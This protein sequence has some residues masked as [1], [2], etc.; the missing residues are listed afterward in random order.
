MRERVLE[1]MKNKPEW[2]KIRPIYGET[3]QEVKRLIKESNLHT[4]CEE[5][6]CPNISE[7]FSARTATFM[8]L[9][10]TCTRTCKFCN[11]N[12]GKPKWY[13]VGEPIRVGSACAKLDLRFAVITSVARDDLKDGGAA[14]FAET[15]RQIKEQNPKCRVELLIPDLQGNWDALRIILDSNPDV[16]AHNLE[17]V[18]RL[19]SRVRPEAIYER[20]L[21][22]LAKSHEYRSD[23][24]V[25]SGI[26]AGLGETEPE[27]R[28]LF[29]DAAKHNCQIMTIGQYLRPS[30]WHHPVVEYRSPDWFAQMKAE[31]ETAGIPYIESGPLVRSSYLAHK[32]VAGYR[33]RLNK[34]ANL[35][36]QVAI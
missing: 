29:S 35:R 31:G 32:Q 19:Y 5:A 14:I 36:Q 2:L 22:L 13:D 3:Y 9:G 4:V 23:I 34:L 33:D 27:L 17:T 12:K 1:D 18:P 15:T 25:K 6:N 10:D 20:S 30:Y 21:E 26:M 16:L 11:V 28:Q 7:C 8:I 24:I